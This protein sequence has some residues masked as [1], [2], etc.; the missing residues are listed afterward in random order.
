MFTI[1]G[2]I[3]GRGYLRVCGFYA[4]FFSGPIPR[5]GVFN[6]LLDGICFA[7]KDTVDAEIV[8]ETISVLK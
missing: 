3:V 1:I 4:M 8:V 7:F 2:M 5:L 6:I